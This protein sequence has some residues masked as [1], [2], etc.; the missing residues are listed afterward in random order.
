MMT[1]KQFDIIPILVVLFL[2]FIIAFT[3]GCASVISP[4][5]EIRITEYGTQGTVIGAFTGEVGGCRVT[6]TG[7]VNA[8]ITYR[9]ERCEVRHAVD[10]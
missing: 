6:Q 9:G 1:P 4:D 5:N 8:E 10:K 7:K 2:I 3:S